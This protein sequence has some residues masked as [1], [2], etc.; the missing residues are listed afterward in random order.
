MR[1]EGQLGR[2]GGAA[3]LVRD[4]VQLFGRAANWWVTH[5][6][7]GRNRRRIDA[8]RQRSRQVQ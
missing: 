2:R 1:D 7:I 3:G 4:L 5:S 8:V 6:P